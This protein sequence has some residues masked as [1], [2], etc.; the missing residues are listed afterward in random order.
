MLFYAISSLVL[1]SG[2]RSNDFLVQRSHRN[3]R[4][5]TGRKSNEAKQMR[6]L[7]FT[8]NVVL[9]HEIYFPSK[10]DR[11]VFTRNAS[12]FVFV[13]W[14]SCQP[15][16][17]SLKFL[18]NDEM[19]TTMTMTMVIVMVMVRV[20][21]MMTMTMMM[22]TTTTTTTTTTIKEILKN[23]PIYFWSHISPIRCSS[24]HSRE[25]RSS[26]HKGRLQSSST[27]R[28]TILLL[29]TLVPCHHIYET[30]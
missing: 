26:Q 4:P 3:Y 27:A 18:N 13:L 19:T 30:E 9:L 29:W 25:Q 10:I 16:S 5:K 24:K 8:Y 28:Q 12:F 7:Y 14:C 1:K 11:S 20:M 23:L 15:S 22:M 17:C 21:V 2:F 6:F